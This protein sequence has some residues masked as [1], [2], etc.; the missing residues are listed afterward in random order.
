[1]RLPAGEEALRALYPRRRVRHLRHGQGNARAGVLHLRLYRKARP[2][3]HGALRTGPDAALLWRPEHARHVRYAAAPRQHRHPR[4]RRERSAR[5]AQRS[6]CNRH[7]HDGERASRLPEVGKHHRSF[8]LAQVAGIPD[9]FRRLLHQQA[10]VHRVLPQGVV[11]RCRN[12]R[13]RL[14]LRLVAEGSL[15]EGRPGLHAY[16]HVRAHEAGRHQ[17]L[18]QLGNEPLPLGPECRQCAPLD[19]E[20]RLA[21][22]GRPGRNRVG[23]LLEGS[24]HEPVRDPDDGVLPP[25]RAHL[26]EAGHHPELRSL[27][28]VA[29]P[30]SRAVGSGQA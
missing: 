30:G 8:Q 27:A 18:L 2:C 20:P 13:E 23:G 10:E 15:R 12:R 17:G 29:L 7:G 19:G 3:R 1:M 25:L 26:R 9:V 4:R 11:R 5:R 24:G 6:G 16:L 14:R 28:A 21:R 22:R